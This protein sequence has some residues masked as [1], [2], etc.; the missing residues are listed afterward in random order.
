MKIV[1]ATKNI[2]LL[3]LWTIISM[4]IGY[5]ICDSGIDLVYH[6]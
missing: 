4:G 6:K 2:L 5:G 1:N 3:A